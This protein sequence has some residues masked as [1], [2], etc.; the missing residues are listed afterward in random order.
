MNVKP[1]FLL[2][3]L[4]VLCHGVRAESVESA[5]LHPREAEAVAFARSWLDLLEAGKADESFMML[6]PIFKANL[7]E[8]TWRST[9]AESNEQ[10]GK[11][12]SRRL[13]RVVWY[14]DPPDAP[15]PG[16]YVAVEFDSDYELRIGTSNTSFSIP[17][18][19]N[20]LG[21]C[22]IN[23]PCYKNPSQPRMAL[24]ANKRLERP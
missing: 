13:Q 22:A 1:S 3:L 21:S 16:T 12:L 14:E 8:A 18:T 11:L 6:T 15:L 23:Q 4:A 7:T 2:I 19:G 17:S 24:A 5:P 9:V 10:L 20:R